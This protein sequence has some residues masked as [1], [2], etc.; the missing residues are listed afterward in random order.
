MDGGQYTLPMKEA[1]VHRLLGVM[2]EALPRT[3]LGYTPEVEKLY[4]EHR[5]VFAERWKEP[6]GIPRRW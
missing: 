1:E 4:R 3:S 5:E 2:Q 6:G